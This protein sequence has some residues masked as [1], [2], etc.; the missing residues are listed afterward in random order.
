ME[1]LHSRTT[2]TAAWL[3]VAM[4]V[5]VKNERTEVKLKNTFLAVLIF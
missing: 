5:V 2:E 3:G 4:S 1:E